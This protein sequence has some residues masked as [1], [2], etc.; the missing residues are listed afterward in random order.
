VTLGAT[1]TTEAAAGRTLRRGRRRS[2]AGLVLAY[3]ISQLGTAMSGLALPWL[4]LVTT[5]SAAKTGLAGALTEAIGLGSALLAT[6]VAM[7]ATTLA[8]F[9]FPAWRGLNL[10]PPAA[11]ATAAAASVADLD[12]PLLLT[13]PPTN[14]VEFANT[15]R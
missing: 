8:P 2:L 14:A 3:G 7:L 1:R 4:V 6:G 15:A 13:F 12:R 11:G 5:G 9:V 10:Q